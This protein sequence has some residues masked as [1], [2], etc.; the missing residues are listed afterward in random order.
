MLDTVDAAATGVF[1]VSLAVVIWELDNGELA[2]DPSSEAFQ[3]RLRSVMA[4]Y[5]LQHDPTA[6]KPDE[7]S[8]EMRL[9]LA[10]IVDKVFKMRSDSL[11]A[12]RELRPLKKLPT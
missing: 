5:R 3:Q 4:E 9:G 1:M 8:R 10:S 7:L 6:Q 11:S 2:N 12:L